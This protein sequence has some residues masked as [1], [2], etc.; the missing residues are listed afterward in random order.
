MTSLIL[1]FCGFDSAVSDVIVWGTQGKFELDGKEILIGH[2]DIVTS[3]G[4]L[5]AQLQDNLGG[6][7]SGV[8]IRPF[9]YLSTSG[10]LNPVRVTIECT[11]GQYDSAMGFARAQVGK[12]YDAPDLIGNFILGRNWRDPNA[13]WCSELAIEAVNH[14]GI[15]H[16]PLMATC[17]HVSPA[18][19]YA[20]T[21]TYGPVT[22]VPMVA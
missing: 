16:Y 5:G 6:K 12:P 19:A 1:Q 17:N 11:Q 7:P 3:E 22:A 8:Q 10:G 15:F 14:G 18:L 21:S 4:L 13:W 2:V 9:D 20:V